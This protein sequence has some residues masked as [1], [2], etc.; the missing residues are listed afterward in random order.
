VESERELCTVAVP[1]ASTTR[2]K[3][4]HRFDDRFL[5][6]STTNKTASIPLLP[7]RISLHFATKIPTHGELN[8]QSIRQ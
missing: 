3:T 4:L 2:Q 1:T 8:F 6:T 5:Q 7:S